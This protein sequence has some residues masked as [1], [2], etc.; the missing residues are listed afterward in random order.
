MTQQ[1]VYNRL[2]GYGLMLQKPVGLMLQKPEMG[3]WHAF[4]RCD[5]IRYVDLVG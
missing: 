2:L 5:E 1:S 3:I 4:C